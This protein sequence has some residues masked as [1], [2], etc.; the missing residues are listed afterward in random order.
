MPKVP[1]VIPPTPRAKGWTTY[2]RRDIAIVFADGEVIPTEFRH[3]KERPATEAEIAK[4]VAKRQEREEK[5]RRREE[6]H[7]RPDWDDADAIRAVIEMM[8]Y[9]NH[10]LDNLTPEE[11]RALRI[12]I[13]GEIK[14]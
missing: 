7:A 9:D 8:E 10:P 5:S 11:W 4:E 13:C 2:F 3:L 12:K 1:K 6:F 14:K